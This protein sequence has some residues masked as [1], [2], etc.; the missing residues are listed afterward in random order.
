MNFVCKRKNINP[1]VNKE[2]FYFPESGPDLTEGNR[3]NSPGASTNERPPQKKLRK[4][5]FKTR[6]VIHV[7]DYIYC[8]MMRVYFILL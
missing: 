5:S 2:L 7:S 1:K 8:Y 6:P 4:K 3:G